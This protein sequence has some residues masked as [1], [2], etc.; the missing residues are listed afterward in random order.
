[1]NSK[2]TNFQISPV[3]NYNEWDDIV[4]RSLEGSI[5]SKS[6]YIKALR[7]NF[8]LLFVTKGNSVKAGIF[9]LIDKKKQNCEWDD[10]VVYNG[11]LFEKPHPKQNY[12]KMISDQFEVTSFVIPQLSEMYSNIKITTSPFLKDMR[13]FLWYNYSE[14]EHL[15]CQLNLRYTTHVNIEGCADN[16]DDDKKTL[17]NELGSSRRQEIRYA[18]RDNIYAI[19]SLDVHSLARCYEMSMNKK[20]FFFP[21][22]YYQRIEKLTAELIKNKIGRLF[23]V[24]NSTNEIESAAFFAWD[25]KRAYYLFGA[26]DPLT[27]K[28]YSGTIVLWDA[29]SFLNQNGIKEVDMEGVNNPYHG[30]FKL[31]M[32]G[33]TL[34]AYYQVTWKGKNND[35]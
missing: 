6:S 25:N 19:D 12:A 18:R 10:L 21:P 22:L 14:D 9:L 7:R 29:F 34:N 33:T 26:S 23:V 17:F 1:M 35:K 27:R 4:D 15:K 20:K 28:S 30:W 8:K 2:K 3:K 31:G 32:G 16:L 11:I 5:Y 24:K 13:P